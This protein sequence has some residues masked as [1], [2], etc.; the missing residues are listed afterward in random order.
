MHHLVSL[1]DRL[2]IEVDTPAYRIG[3][4]SR[5]RIRTYMYKAQSREFNH[6]YSL[7]GPAALEATRKVLDLG[8]HEA[9]S[10]RSHD[11]LTPARHS[12]RGGGRF[13]F[14]QYIPKGSRSMGI[15]SP[16]RYAETSQFIPDQE[17][18]WSGTS[19]PD[20]DMVCGCYV[21]SDSSWKSLA[22]DINVSSNELC[23]LLWKAH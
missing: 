6:L 11:R 5:Y 13:T 18:E 1:F 10:D 23:P 20:G 17:S 3:L 8:V 21:L 7:H 19:S 9:R 22:H 4:L 14:Q 2:I 12:R 16:G 15:D